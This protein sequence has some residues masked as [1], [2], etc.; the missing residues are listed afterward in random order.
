VLV[1]VVGDIIFLNLFIHLI[2]T[3][4]REVQLT[5]EEEDVVIGQ[6]HT[7]LRPFLLRRTKAQASQF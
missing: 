5:K 1:I 4:L 6:L 2:D 3:E 7:V